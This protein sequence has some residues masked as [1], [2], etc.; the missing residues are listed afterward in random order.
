MERCTLDANVELYTVDEICVCSNGAANYR[1]TLALVCARTHVH[2]MCGR[3][4]TDNDSSSLLPLCIAPRDVCQYLYRLTAIAPD[5]RLYRGVTVIGKLDIVWRSAM[6]ERGRLQTSPLQR[7][8]CVHRCS[9][10]HDHRH[11]AA[12]ISAA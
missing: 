1:G 2:T 6:G 5:E 4:D 10:T 3:S 12:A 7:M 11:P 8:V 9:C